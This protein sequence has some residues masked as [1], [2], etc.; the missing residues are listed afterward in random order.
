MS[1]S[2]DVRKQMLQ[3]VFEYNALPLRR[4]GDV[5]VKDVLED[6]LARGRK[7]TRCT[8][9]LWL[10][11]KGEAAGWEKEL[12]LVNG[13]GTTVWRKPAKEQEV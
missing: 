8:A 13:R 7:M 12:V 4:P 10:K 2:D 6:A 1:V 11:K 5:T 3:E 9:A